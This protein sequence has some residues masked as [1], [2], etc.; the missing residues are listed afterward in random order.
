ML[1]SGAIQSG[2]HKWSIDKKQTWAMIPGDDC[3]RDKLMNPEEQNL[4]MFIVEE[5][6]TD[7]E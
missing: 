5:G 2:F 4:E 1:V 6:N 3:R 7:N